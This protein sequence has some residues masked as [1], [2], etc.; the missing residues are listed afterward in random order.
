MPNNFTRDSNCKA[1]WRLESGALTTDSISTN[2]LTNTGVDEGT[3]DYKEGAC[4]GGFVRTSSD[5][6][7]ITNTNLAA[8]FPGKSDGTHPPGN[9][10]LCFW[11]KFSALNTIH[12]PTLYYQTGR[13]TVVVNYTSSNFYLRFGT[14][15]P[16]WTYVNHGSAL[17]TGRWYHVGVTYNN[18]SKAYTV[19]IWDATAGAIL[20]SDLSGTMTNAITYTGGGGLTLGSAD[21]NTLDGLLDE[22]VV[23][24]DIL[25]SSEID[26]IRAGTYNNLN[27]PETIAVSLSA[28]ATVTEGLVMTESPAAALALVCAVTDVL[29]LGGGGQDAIMLGCHF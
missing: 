9:I 19:R 15:S 22:V 20:G 8:G 5:N 6:L 4:C 21:T 29:I 16:T 12:P 2:T 27:W 18:T 17:A 11:V 1:L 28:S 10:S 26:A 7:A 25:S 3:T 14:Y 24:D 23:F 13:W